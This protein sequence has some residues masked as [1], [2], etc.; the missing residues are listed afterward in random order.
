VVRVI[1]H[2]PFSHFRV[3]HAALIAGNLGAELLIYSN[4]TSKAALDGINQVLEHPEERA[5]VPV[6]VTES[7]EDALKFAEGQLALVDPEEDGGLNK[8]NP[9]DT[10]LLAPV[11]RLDELDVDP[12]IT[13]GVGAEVGELAALAIILHELGAGS[14]G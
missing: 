8:L 11:E 9:S 7:L 2:Q 3:N 6:M 10:L 1:Y 14:N 13:V 4:P 5:G 12:D